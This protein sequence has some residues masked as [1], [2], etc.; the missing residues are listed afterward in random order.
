MKPSREAYHLHSTGDI[1]WLGTALFQNDVKM[2]EKIADCL[3]ISQP[4]IS[5]SREGLS[6]LQE[7][8]RKFDFDV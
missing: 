5:R 7:P 4:D 6:L 1:T 2:Y 3:D 8:A